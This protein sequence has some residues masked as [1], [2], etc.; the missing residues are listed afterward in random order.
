MQLAK[1]LNR[2]ASEPAL[3]VT[4]DVYPK[5]PDVLATIKPGGITMTAFLSARGK[6]E[7][8]QEVHYGHVL[9]PPASPEAIQAWRMQHRSHPLPADLE[10]SRSGSSLGSRCS[11]P[12]RLNPSSTIATS[13]SP[14]IAMAG[15]S[16]DISSRQWEGLKFRVWDVEEEVISFVCRDIERPSA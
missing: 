6:S 5:T 11:E 8:Q 4:H 14:T 15:L 3:A 1:F 2:I 10:G 13:R 16:E 9:G 7:G 12:K